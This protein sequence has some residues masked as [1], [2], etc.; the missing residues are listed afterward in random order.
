VRLFRFDDEVSIPISEPGS[1][2]RIGPLIG[3]GSNVRVEVVHLPADGMIGRHAASAPQLFAVVAG[4]GWVRGEEGDRRDIRAGYAALWEAGEDH[5]AGTD[6]GLMAVCIEGELEMSAVAVTQDIVVV[7]Y[8]SDWPNWFETLRRHVWPAVEDIALQIE[9]VGSTAVPGLAAKPIIDMDVVIASERDVGSAIERL[10]TIGYHWRGDLGVP[11]RQA[12]T[13]TRD[14]GLPPH[15]L[16]LVVESSKA[17]LDHVL[18]RDTLREDAG[19]RERY[20]DL[21]RRNVELARRDIDVYVAAKA[22][23]V[24]EILTRARA[25]KGLP[26]ETYW[27][28]DIESR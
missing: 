20:A 6:E 10:A 26:P 11:G 1:C 7:G 3:T 22:S 2:F 28:P 5:E 9:H 14:D 12:F 16:Y 24:A 18:L 15:H 8:D 25:E 21:K 17:L 23:F 27:Q 13:A 4:H 19:A